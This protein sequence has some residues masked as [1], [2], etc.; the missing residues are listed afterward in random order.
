MATVTQAIYLVS[1][2]SIHDSQLARLLGLGWQIWQGPYCCLHFLMVLPLALCHSLQEAQ[3]SAPLR[4]PPS[5]Q[6]AH[7]EGLVFSV[8]VHTCCQFRA[9]I[10]NCLCLFS[11]L[12]V[13]RIGVCPVSWMVSERAEL[14][15]VRWFI[16]SPA[17]DQSF[18]RQLGRVRVQLSARSP[19]TW[20]PGSVP[21][22]K[23]SGGKSCL[24]MLL[25]IARLSVL[26]WKKNSLF[27]QVRKF[28]YYV[29]RSCK[30]TSWKT[31]PSDNM[32]VFQHCF[33]L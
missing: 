4:S 18:I 9:L 3:L 7:W 25:R 5:R 30:R 16:L 22:E 15:Q 23:K 24:R 2:K 1:I 19:G 31:A 12:S 29:I 11:S 20:D 14:N 17:P 10:L 13:E 27:P 6:P 28:I 21:K 26:K 8:L 33:K 32:T